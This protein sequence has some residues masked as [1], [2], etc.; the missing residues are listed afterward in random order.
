A[1]IDFQFGPVILLGMR[2]TAVEVCP[3]AA[4]RMAPLEERDPELMIDSLKGRRLLEGYRGRAPINLASLSKLLLRFSQVVMDLEAFIE[5]I[6]LNPVI[7]SPQASVIA[8]VRIMLK[9]R[10]AA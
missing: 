10:K 3:D 4:I 8:D 1:K 7:C 9:A 5:S 6:D 2:G